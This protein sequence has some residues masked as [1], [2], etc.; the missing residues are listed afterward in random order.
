MTTDSEQHK[1]T[2]SYSSNQQYVDHNSLQLRLETQNLLLTFEESLSG[3]RTMIYQDADGNFSFQ[4]IKVCQG[5]CNKEGAK[6]ITNRLR[7]LANPQTFQGNLKQD[8]FEDI[9]TRIHLNDSIWL[10]GQREDFE[11]IPSN[12]VIVMSMIID[13]VE[14]SLSSVVNGFRTTQLTPTLKTV[15]SNNNVIKENGGRFKLPWSN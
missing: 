6:Q 5:F 7:M 12:Y 13:F 3:Y 4:E 15:E 14:L 1:G 10:Q 9:I 11:I 2:T 8:I